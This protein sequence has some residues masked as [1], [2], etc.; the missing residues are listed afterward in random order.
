MKRADIGELE[1]QTIARF[2]NGL[3]PA[4][5]KIVDFQPYKNL[6][7]LLHQAS[8]AERHVQADLKNERIKAYYASLKEPTQPSTSDQGPPPSSSKTPNEVN[9]PTSSECNRILASINE[10]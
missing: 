8:K 7:E 6:V 9:N 3:S 4:I 2:L 5:K 1:E 10:N